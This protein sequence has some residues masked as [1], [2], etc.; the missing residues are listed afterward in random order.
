MHLG[1]S[2][3]S[4]GHECVQHSAGG[5]EGRGD[6][7]G[8][9]PGDGGS[10]IHRGSLCCWVFTHRLEAQNPLASNAHLGCLHC[11]RGIRR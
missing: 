8:A 5:R 10:P 4:G 7:R 6:G 11:P 9:S 3:C 1:P 2:H